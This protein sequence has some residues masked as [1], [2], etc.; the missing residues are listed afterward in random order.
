MSAWISDSDI[1]TSREG[2]SSRIG[3]TV[4]RVGISCSVTDEAESAAPGRWA[5]VGQRT[6]SSGAGE[7]FDDPLI[8]GVEVGEDLVRGPAGQVDVDR[9]V[10]LGHTVGL[11]VLAPQLADL[12]SADEERVGDLPVEGDAGDEGVPVQ[13][14]DRLGGDPSS[15]TV[16]VSTASTTRSTRRPDPARSATRWAISWCQSRGVQ[17]C[18]RRRAA[19][20]KATPTSL[21]ASVWA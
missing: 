21:T 5:A 17:S 10:K 6:A 20:T 2:P 18:P 8:E 7:V 19:A 4:I 1:A 14:G 12:E 3:V 16:Q 13:A 15:R 9:R 11:V